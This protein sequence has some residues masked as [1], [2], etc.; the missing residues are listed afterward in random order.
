ML[1]FK[2]QRALSRSFFQDANPRRSAVCHPARHTQAWLSKHAPAAIAMFDR[3]M[4]YLAVSRRR[5]ADYHLNDQ[6]IISKS[7]YEIFPD[8]P[9]RWKKVHQRALSGCAKVF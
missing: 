5:L 8:I 9:D 4:H 2:D 7:H 6:N 3:A 1:I